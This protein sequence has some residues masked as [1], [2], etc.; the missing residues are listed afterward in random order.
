MIYV[1]CVDNKAYIGFED[2][3]IDPMET[4]DL[5]IGRVYKAA[6][7]ST[8]D[9]RLGELR[10]Y[11]DTGEDYLFPASYFDP[12]L[13]NGDLETTD[14]LS[15]SL[16]IYCSFSII[17]GTRDLS[18]APTELSRLANFSTGA[19]DRSFHRILRRYHLLEKHPARR[20]PSCSEV[21]QRSAA[22]MG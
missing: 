11:D 19:P 17:G 10:V 18:G 15:V 1:K 20:S 5:T 22:R 21:G 7:P 12:Y 16:N 2:K 13:P 6:L 4:T 8:D 14:S 3:P 9:L